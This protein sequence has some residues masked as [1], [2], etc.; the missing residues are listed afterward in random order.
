MKERE[1]TAE[2]A[3]FRLVLRWFIGLTR[4]ELLTFARRGEEKKIVPVDVPSC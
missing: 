4:L 2:V 3:S 1:V